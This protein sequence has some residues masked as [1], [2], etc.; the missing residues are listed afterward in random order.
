MMCF[1]IPLCLS[2]L[3]VLATSWNGECSNPINVWIL[4]VGITSLLSS[5][6][7]YRTFKGIP[8]SEDSQD[9]QEQR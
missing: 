2:V 1:Q 9:E 8:S 7:T 5:L 4:V 6:F 3:I